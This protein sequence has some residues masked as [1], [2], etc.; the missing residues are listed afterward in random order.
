MNFLTT[1][2]LTSLSN[3]TL[4]KKNNSFTGAFENMQP[5]LIRAF[6]I[7]NEDR[8]FDIGSFLLEDRCFNIGSFLLYVFFMIHPS[9]LFCL[10]LYALRQVVAWFG[11][12]EKDISEIPIDTSGGNEKEYAKLNHKYIEKETVPNWALFVLCGMAPAVFFVWSGTKYGPKGD[13]YANLC[14]LFR[15]IGSTWFVTDVL[16]V[17]CARPRPH[18]YQRLGFDIKTKK[19]QE[20]DR[21]QIQDAFMSFPS[22]HASLSF[23]TMVRVSLEL[24]Q[25]LQKWPLHRL[26]WTPVVLAFY[27]ARTRV[28]DH[29]HHP[30]DI[31]AGAV[32]GTVF[33][34]LD[35]SIV[36]YLIIFLLLILV[37]QLIIKEIKRKLEETK[38]DGL[39]IT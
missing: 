32:L 20:K 29:W 38:I 11:Q 7:E 33:A 19:C 16:K 1:L 34:L 39:Q 36:V 9:I 35:D 10:G 2:E 30:E 25:I 37:D 12:E 26:A 28:L 14:S 24:T 5:F 31:I 13:E 17:R 3:I 4:F 8:C 15:S 27:I 22:G 18:I 21:R 6:E 23:T